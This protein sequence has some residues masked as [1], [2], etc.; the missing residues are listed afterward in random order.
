MTRKII[1]TCAV[2]GSIYTPTMSPHLPITGA[3]IATASIEAAKAGASIIHL[4]ARD[5][6]DGRP[7]ANVDHFM[8][9]IPVFWSRGMGQRQSPSQ[10]DITLVRC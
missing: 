3:E 1:I 7:S 4:H 2:T 10:T 5:P 8:N 6:K 9:F